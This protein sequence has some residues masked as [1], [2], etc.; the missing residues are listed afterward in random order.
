M[1]TYDRENQAY[2]DD[3]LKILSFSFPLWP[4]SLP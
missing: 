1:K 2:L 3:L 4:S